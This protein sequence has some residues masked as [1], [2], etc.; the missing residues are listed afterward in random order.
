MDIVYVNRCTAGCSLE[1]G[2]DDA[3]NRRSSVIGGPTTFLDAAF[4]Q[5]VYDAVLT[6]LRSVVAP[7]DIRITTNDPG[8]VPRREVILAGHPANLGLPNVDGLAPWLFG[9]PVDNVIG[10]AFASYIGPD[11]DRLCWAAARQIGTLYGL[12]AALHC[13]DL[14]SHIDD[15]GLKTFTNFAAPCGELALRD[16]DTA[17]ERHRQNSAAILAVV[18]GQAEV[19][20]RN[21]FE[22]GGPS[23]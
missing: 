12:D 11:A 9:A 21:G 13:P 5:A 3:I 14:M 22:A 4:P 7:Y 1:A 6:C 15:C 8:P 16:C 17:P 18:A 2:I 19:V 23:P 20:F 10:F